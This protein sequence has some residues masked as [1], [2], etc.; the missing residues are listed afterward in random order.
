MATSIISLPLVTTVAA[1]V[2]AILEALVAA[3]AT[4]DSI[5]SIAVLKDTLVGTMEVRQIRMQRDA[6][7]DTSTDTLVKVLPITTDLPNSLLCHMAGSRFGIP[8]TIATTTLKKQLVALSGSYLQVRQEARLVA[9]LATEVAM[10]AATPMGLGA[11]VVSTAAM[12]VNM[13]AGLAMEAPPTAMDMAT[14][15][16]IAV[17]I[18]TVMVTATLMAMATVTLMVTTMATE[19]TTNMARRRKRR[20]TRAAV[21]LAC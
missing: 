10:A 4:E 7:L 9:H 21:S 18:L 8:T 13:V 11:M 19:V 15:T 5:A 20:R 3:K 14:H 2:L 6:T 17:A 16:T 1:M 12:E